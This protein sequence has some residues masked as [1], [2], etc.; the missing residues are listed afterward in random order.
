M[1]DFILDRCPN[2]GEVKVTLKDKLGKDVEY[3]L[4]R[5]KSNGCVLSVFENGTERDQITFTPLD[6]KALYLLVTIN[7]QK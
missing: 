2:F 3:I 6:L 4:H 1:K 5:V 7:P